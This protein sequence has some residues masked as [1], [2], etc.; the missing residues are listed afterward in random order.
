[1]ITRV[2]APYSPRLTLLAAAIGALL[3]GGTTLAAPSP[4]AGVAASDAAS[5]A[6][7]ELEHLQEIVVTTASR[8]TSSTVEKS[9]SPIDVVSSSELLQ[10]GQTNLRDALQNLYPS[11]TQQAGYQGQQGEGVKVAAL[12]G[13]DPKDTLV[14]VNGIR[15]HRTALYLLGQS[16]TDL[17][18]IPTSAVDHIEILKDGAAAQYGSDAIAGVINIILKRDDK[19]G[20]ATL[21]YG[22]YGSSVGDF[23]NLRGRGGIALLDQGFKLG[24]DGGFINFSASVN[25]HKATKVYGPYPLS[26]PI[27]P[28]LAD[29]TADPRETADTRYRQIQGQ[30]AVQNYS[31]GYNAELPIG[32]GITAYS[33]ST[34]AHRYSQG[35]GFFRTARSPQNYL[36]VYPD[37]YMPEFANVEDDFQSVFGVKGKV[38]GWNWDLST[39]YGGDYA[40]IYTNDSINASLGPAYEGI[41]DFYDG[42]EVSG[43]WVTDLNLNHEFDTGLF[44]KPLTASA[45]LEYRRETFSTT[46]GDFASYAQGTFVWP[47]GTLNAGVAPN[48]G[49][50]GMKGFDPRDTGAWAR[51]VDAV[52]VDLNQALT[53]GWTADLA[54]R[55]ERYSDFGGNAN[56]K[57]S[58]R[59]EFTD[60]FAIRG[61]VSNGFSA[62]TLQ[63]EHY[64][65]STGG[66]V[67]DPLSGVLTQ[68]YTIAA[69]PTS[70]VAKALGADALTP[71]HSTNLS[72]GFVLK[73]LDRTTVTLDAYSISIRDRIVQTPTLQGPTV[74][75]LLNAAGITNVTSVTYFTNA[76]H[77]VTRGIDLGVE[78]FDDFG[79][80]GRVR[81]TLSGN[82]NTTVVKSLQGIPPA[83]AASGIGWNR[84]IYSSLSQFYPKNITTI[85]ADWRVQKLEFNLRE[86][87]YSQTNFESPNGARLDQHS[88]PAFITDLDIGYVIAVNAKVSIGATN[89][90]NKRPS[91]QSASAIQFGSVPTAA[92][93][94]NWYSPFGNDGG[95]YYIR[96]KYS[97]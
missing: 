2:R 5:T 82:E 45:G 56:G 46:P 76:A 90:L 72:A 55:Y 42:R 8:A 48:P 96:A 58:T 88:A 91:Q 31:G 68:Q 40:K 52:F 6:D 19:G 30:P 65:Q 34:Y 93:A 92:P 67:T 74:V 60:A 50:S 87:H 26:S 20:S 27:Y 89:L 73:P 94:Y 24:D 4:E 21:G 44:T 32:D 78:R 35:W 57:L 1:V 39:S 75:G 23:E 9:A 77:T 70:A 15:R 69:T 14:L 29:G 12:H 86:R 66:Y 51:S 13:L 17:D 97:W 80:F 84:A 49:A 37:G 43:E 11:Y 28:K 47:A 7:G 63:Q 3:A 53:Q 25:V 81:W 62:P 54:G 18:M 16:P 33:F 83:L 71:E 59:Y 38:L 79:D 95:Y 41:H 61:T 64:T 36:D 10:T 85:D 22:Q